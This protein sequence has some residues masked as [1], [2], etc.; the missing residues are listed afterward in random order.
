MFGSVLALHWA[1]KPGQLANTTVSLEEFCRSG[2]RF[3]PAPSLRGS[4][5]NPTRWFIKDVNLCLC[6]I[7]I[8]RKE[9]H[10][11]GRFSPDK[12]RPHRQPGPLSS[13]PAAS[14]SRSNPGKRLRDVTGRLQGALWATS[15]SNS[16][17]SLTPVLYIYINIYIYGIYLHISRSGSAETVL[18]FIR[19]VD[20]MSEITE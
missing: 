3:L 18:L 5:W 1:V 7:L 8:H 9:T 12:L 16:T 20:V 4:S 10:R 13:R 6:S 11:L 15:A 2:H 17:H 14:H 19:H